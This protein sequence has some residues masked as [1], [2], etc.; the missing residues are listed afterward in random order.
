MIHELG[1]PH[2]ADTTVIMKVQV[3]YNGF[4]DN[5]LRGGVKL[6]YKGA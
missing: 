6:A 1:C 2:L 4:V 3:S 5:P